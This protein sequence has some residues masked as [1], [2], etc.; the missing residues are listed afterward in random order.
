MSY[1]TLLVDLRDGVATLTLNRPE[2]RNALNE[3]MIRELGLALARLEGDAEAR[4]V[5][6]CS[7]LAAAPEFGRLV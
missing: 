3:T 1:E 7:A 6:S 2:S 5:V 4:V